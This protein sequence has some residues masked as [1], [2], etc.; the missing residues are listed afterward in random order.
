MRNAGVYLLSVLLI[1]GALSA[2]VSMATMQWLYPQRG[3]DRAPAP[4]HSAPAAPASAAAPEKQPAQPQPATKNAVNP[5]FAAT[6][7]ETL[8]LEFIRRAAGGDVQGAAALSD[9]LTAEALRG[10]VTFHSV[11]AQRAATLPGP[12]GSVNVQV[13]VL[14]GPNQTRSLYQLTVA[15]GKVRSLKGPM[16]PEGGFGPFGLT[17]L[18]EQARPLDMTPYRGRGLVLISPRTPEPGLAELV[19]QLQAACGPQGVDVVLL[20]DIRSPDWVAAARAAGYTGPVWRVKARLEDVPL[21]SKGSLMGAYGVLI[22]REGFAVASL[23]ALDPFQY[24][25]P[26][27]APPAIATSVFRAY[28]LMP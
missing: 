24:G 22:D 15:G 9:G 25:L 23:A 27:E 8:A 14:I 2:V 6:P 3:T 20:M 11:S 17:L 12:R 5:A 26:D 1:A 19:R 7:E 18:D 28:G 21:V 10:S 16:A 4:A 13:W